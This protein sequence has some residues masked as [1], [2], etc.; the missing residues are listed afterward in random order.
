MSDGVCRSCGRSLTLPGDFSPRTCTDVDPTNMCRDE[1]RKRAASKAE[2]LLRT[3]K[4]QRVRCEWKD[5][6][7]E[8]TLRQATVSSCPRCQRAPIKVT[9]ERQKKTAS[10]DTY[11]FCHCCG[12]AKSIAKIACDECRQLKP[13]VTHRYGLTR[14]KWNEFL[15]NGLRIANV[16]PRWYRVLELIA[17]V[18]KGDSETTWLAEYIQPEKRGIPPTLEAQPDASNTDQ[19]DIVEFSV[20]EALTLVTRICKPSVVRAHMGTSLGVTDS[21]ASD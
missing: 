14:A 6:G 8:W 10:G 3:K 19:S 13:S 17:D 7:Y 16:D 18:T 9:E 12:R 21:L 15:L 4:G 2:A 11:P 1:L 20:E 5:C